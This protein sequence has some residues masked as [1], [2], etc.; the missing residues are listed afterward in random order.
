MQRR[1]AYCEVPKLA[2]VYTFAV[3][4]SDPLAKLGYDLRLVGV[5][6]QAESDYAHRLAVLP[7]D[8]LAPDTDDITAQR[9]AFLRWLRDE[10]I[11]I[12]M[13]SGSETEQRL[14]PALPPDIRVVSVVNNATRGHYRVA[15]AHHERIHR[16]V[17]LSP[18]L[19]RDIA[20]YHRVPEHKVQLIPYGIDVRAFRG[21]RAA[22]RHGA[23]AS[24]PLRVL[25]FGRMC[26]SAKGIFLIP[27]ILAHVEKAG[28]PFHLTVIGDGPDTPRF[29][30]LIEQGG[31]SDRCTY[32]DMLRYDRVGDELS[33]HDVMVMPSRHEG[34]GL[35]L[36]ES[37]AAGC[38]PIASRLKGVTDYVISDERQGVLCRVGRA[39]EFAAAIVA[40][41]GDRVR[42]SR[43]AE[44]AT[45]RVEAEFTAERMASRYVEL[46][47]TIMKEP[48]LARPPPV[49]TTGRF[50]PVVQP[51]LAAC[52]RAVPVLVKNVVRTVCE[53]AGW[54]V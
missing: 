54:T 33:R 49:V 46:F 5:G 44:A 4:L 48:S 11:D 16:L 30:S 8:V 39:D 2:G 29:L 17:C 40:L 7:A 34:L 47:D 1:V 42:L 45:A 36:L 13:I 32:R 20:D 38:V 52:R 53:R 35:V 22:K 24:E 21:N 23:S 15:T 31:F 27:K 43:M 28:V 3:S 26:D 9:E 25:Y 18:R 37:M 10:A 50:G 14:I 51:F 12:V 41:A 6:P 19:E